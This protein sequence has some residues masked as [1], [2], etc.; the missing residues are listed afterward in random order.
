MMERSSAEHEFNPDQLE[1]CIAIRN[2]SFVSIRVH[3]Y[4]SMVQKKLERN[5][6]AHDPLV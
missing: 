4:S 1:M 5:A 3:R 2:L 6:H